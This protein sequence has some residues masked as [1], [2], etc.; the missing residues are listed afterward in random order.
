MIILMAPCGLRSSVL[1]GELRLGNVGKKGVPASNRAST[2][3]SSVTL[4]LLANLSKSAMHFARLVQLKVLSSRFHD[5]T[6][7][8]HSKRRT[9]EAPDI[10]CTRVSFSR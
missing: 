9:S 4:P 5:V 1:L 8:S 6:T 2:K 7:L 10:A 3:T